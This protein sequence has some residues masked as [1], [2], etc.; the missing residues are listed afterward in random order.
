MTTST[1]FINERLIGP[2]LQNKL[3]LKFTKKLKNKNIFTR[4]CF[5]LLG[6]ENLSKIK[7]KQITLN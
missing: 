2:K 3:I 7:R 1:Y 4:I 5:Q 6:F